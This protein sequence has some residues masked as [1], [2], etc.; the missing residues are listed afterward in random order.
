M[1]DSA[2]ITA[3]GCEILEPKTQKLKQN[4]FKNSFRIVIR[5]LGWIFINTVVLP[6]HLIGFPLQG[7]I[8][9]YHV[10]IRFILTAESGHLADT[11]Q[12]PANKRTVQ[13]GYSCAMCCTIRKGPNEL[14]SK[15][16]QI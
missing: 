10:K 8:Y 3:H 9:S 1:S 14:I 6:W 12:S 2:G 5:S 7:Q 11:P 13:G 4:Y 16:L 15:I